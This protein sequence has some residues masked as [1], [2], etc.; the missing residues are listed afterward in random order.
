[1]ANKIGSKRIGPPCNPTNSPNGCG[2]PLPVSSA[3]KTPEELAKLEARLA[4]DAQRVATAK[5]VTVKTAVEL[6]AEKLVEEKAK[7]ER[8][9]AKE[10]K[11]RA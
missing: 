6:A 11:T 8:K 5:G 3:P 4:R 1:M 7:A 2:R 9:A 10:A